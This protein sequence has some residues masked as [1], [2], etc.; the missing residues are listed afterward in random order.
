MLETKY[1]TQLSD[2]FILY[3][4]TLFDKMNKFAY[5]KDEWL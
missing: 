4:F 3:V 5:M 2:I 1:F